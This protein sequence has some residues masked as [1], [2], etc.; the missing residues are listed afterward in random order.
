MKNGALHERRWEV[1]YD[2]NGNSI[3]YRVNN[4]KHLWEWVQIEPRRS[5]CT[6]LAGPNVAPTNAHE[7]KAL[8]GK[9]VVYMLIS[10][11]GTKKRHFGTICGVERTVISFDNAMKVDLH[12]IYEMRLT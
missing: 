4:G 11:R 5:F 10:D 3:G 7:A 12:Q 2:G 1:A 9:A 8:F 6:Y